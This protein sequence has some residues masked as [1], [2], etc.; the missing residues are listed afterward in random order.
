MLWLSDPNL[1]QASGLGL[2][3]SFATAPASLL[4]APCFAASLAQSGLPAWW[5]LSVQLLL[6]AAARCPCPPLHP[7]C[8]EASLT[9]DC[10]CFAGSFLIRTCLGII[11]AL[12]FLSAS[13]CPLAPPP[14][15]LNFNFPLSG[16]LL[17]LLTSPSC[18]SIFYFLRIPF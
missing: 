16:F 18:F 17:H 9:C 1:A 2:P 12:G 4:E 3:T 6:P 13:P 8:P 14:P 10:L 5:L 15:A 11:C 7:H